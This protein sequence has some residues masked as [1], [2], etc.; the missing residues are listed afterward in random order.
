MGFLNAISRTAESPL[1]AKV[2][3][4][5]FPS[6]GQFGTGVGISFPPSRHPLISIIGH[7]TWISETLGEATKLA[8]AGLDISVRIYVTGDSTTQQPDHVSITESNKEIY[9]KEEKSS[10]PS[11]FEDPAIEIAGVSRPNLK[12]VLEKEADLT[13][14]RMGVT[15]SCD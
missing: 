11:L 1:V 2:R 14:G 6:S 9:E 13:V 4:S 15:G 5:E 10:L 8:P 12:H 3:P 7:I